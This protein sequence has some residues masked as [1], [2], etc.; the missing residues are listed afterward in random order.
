MP[1][2]G[3]DV[4]YSASEVVR[5]GEKRLLQSEA[6]WEFLADHLLVLNQ[7]WTRFLAEQ[8]RLSEGADAVEDRR[9]V[10]ASYAVLAALAL[11]EASDAELRPRPC[12]RRCLRWGVSVTTGVRSVRSD[13]G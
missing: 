4:L 2:Q 11:V 1:V 5:L 7:N 6:D 12:R 3:K 8:R 13:C 10:E 9:E